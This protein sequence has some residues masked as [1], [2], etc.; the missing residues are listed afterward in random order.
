MISISLK[1]A[2][3]LDTWTAAARADGRALVGPWAVLSSALN[4]L[5]LAHRT[6][7]RIPSGG[8]GM[9]GESGCIGA[10]E[11]PRAKSSVAM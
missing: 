3:K 9:A 1:R 2:E 8:G 5:W 11:G 4:P 6:S 7:F 10:A